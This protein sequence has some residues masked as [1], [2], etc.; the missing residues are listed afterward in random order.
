M[1]PQPFVELGV[2][3]L[4]LHLKHLAHTCRGIGK[5][6]LAEHQAPVEVVP[7]LDAVGAVDERAQLAELLPVVTRHLLRH[8][9]LG[10]QVLLDGYEYLV[11]VD[12][13]DEIVGYL[14]ADSLVHY[15]LLLAFG[16][17]YHGSLRLPLLYQRECLQAGKARHVLVEYYEVE[18]LGHG[19]VESV[20][21]VVGRYHIVAAVA[22]K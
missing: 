15:V 19:H 3:L 6:H 7:V 14:A 4:F 22:E 5:L 21:A 20:A 18:R 17:H 10:V 1:A 13:L 2:G 9:L 12:G 16:N 11:G 8:K